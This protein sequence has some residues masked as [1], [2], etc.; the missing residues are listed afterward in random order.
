MKRKN[1]TN[2]EGM[3]KLLNE[4]ST[5]EAQKVKGGRPNDNVG[6]SIGVTINFNDQ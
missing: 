5:K 1:F 4:L 6:I 3:K 2:E